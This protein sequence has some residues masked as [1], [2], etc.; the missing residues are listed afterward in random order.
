MENGRFENRPWGHFEV[1][2]EQYGK[3]KVIHVYPKKRLSYQL[4]HKRSEIWVVQQ[5]VGKAVL[6]D[7]EQNLA[8]GAVILIPHGCKHRIENTDET[9]TLVFIEVQYGTYY[10]EEDRS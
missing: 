8:P 2:H 6:N 10:S 4:H 5:G 3:V 7:K 9:T 1:L